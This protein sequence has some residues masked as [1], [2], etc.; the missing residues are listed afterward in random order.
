LQEKFADEFGITITVAHYPTGA[1]KWNPIEHRMFNEITKNWAG[2]PLET[3]ETVVNFAR[4][5][6]TKT[7]LC[8]E[9]YRDRRVY[10]KG[11]KVPDKEMDKLALTRAKEIGKWNYTIEP[12]VF[13]RYVNTSMNRLNQPNQSR[14]PTSQYTSKMISSEDDHQRIDRTNH[15]LLNLLSNLPQFITGVRILFSEL[16]R[17]P[18]Q[19]VNK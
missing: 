8:V 9:A 17:K 12:R 3:F 13:C 10:E 4:E 11:K 7:G 6:S 5:S 1:G 18:I 16:S 2:Q 15:G 19:T 14:L